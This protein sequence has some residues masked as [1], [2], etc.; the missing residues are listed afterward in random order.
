MADDVFGIVGT[1]QAG[2]FRV[3]DVVAEGGFAVVY[4]AY[5]DSFRADIALKCLKIPGSLSEEDKKDFLDKF[6]EEAELLFRLSSTLPNIVRPLHVGTLDQADGKFVPFIAIEWLQGKVLDE[7]IA[8]RRVAGEP[9]FSIERMIELLTPVAETLDRA[10]KFPG[11]DGKT[12]CVVHR[13]L[14]PENIFIADMHGREVP[15]LLDYGIAKV[16]T[17]AT[18]AAGHQTV[19]PESLN[20]FTPAY[21]APEQWLP[22][23]YG[24]SGPW[25]D[26]WGL[27]LTAVECLCGRP[28]ID[29]ED[30]RAIMGSAIDV[31]RRPTPRT[32]GA[33]VSD[34]VEAVFRRALAVHPKDRYHDV[35]TF[36]A[37]LLDAAGIV[38]AESEGEA[39]KSSPKATDLEPKTAEAKPTGAETN[40][41]PRKKEE[42]PSRPRQRGL[43]LV[44]S[45]HPPPRE[46]ALTPSQVVP[47]S[48]TVPRLDKHSRTSLFR[49]GA[50]AGLGI[51]LTGLLIFGM[52][53]FSGEDPGS[54][55]SGSASAALPPSAPAPDHRVGEL[56]A[57]AEERLSFG[58]LEGAK[59]QLDRA[60]ALAEKDPVVLAALARVEAMRADVH[61]LG[62]RLL[63]ENDAPGLESERR[64]LASRL[65]RVTAASG[66]AE[67]AKPDDAAVLRARVDALRLTGDLA[68]AKGLST[69][70]AWDTTHPETAYVLAA[71]DL[72]AP[73]PAW[74]LAVERLRRAASVERGPGRARAALAFAL[75]SG[76]DFDAARRELEVLSRGGQS[77]P[78]EPA[79]KAFIERLAAKGGAKSAEGL[80]A[81]AEEAQKRGDS[82]EAGRRYDAALD[83]DPEY[84]P[85]L[86]GRADQKWS[87][88]D[89][90]GAVVLYRRASRQDDL[91]AAHRERALARIK[92]HQSAPRPAPKPRQYLGDL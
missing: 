87:L 1:V 41:E 29:A 54:A 43:Q 30:Q 61:W 26:V 79:L 10:H 17:T 15:K 91:D 74:P 71:L 66:A 16:K 59:E 22:K 64:Q 38:R 88:G 31:V 33:T 67:R 77:Y 57:R 11:P 25:T 65:N 69:K 24:Q 75:A 14:K 18:Q 68:G 83:A 23:S 42:L 82:A 52:K 9:P 45:E 47:I 44:D 2:A 27:A 58:D 80:T 63:P 5:H 32:E 84:A 13:D 48:R 60:A 36:W 72:A 56:F 73:A 12:M 55:P 49:L 3:E 92:E 78:L 86:M 85:A 62:V 90:N 51:L 37:D 34:A 50:V 21:G 40:A 6:R 81:L 35:G 53:V 76:G 39:K 8:A 70:I 89:R 7:I 20:A 4:R 46:P 19:S 28:A